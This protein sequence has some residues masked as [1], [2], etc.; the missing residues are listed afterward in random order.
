[1]GQ[2]VYQLGED[3]IFKESLPH[4]S[5]VWCREVAAVVLTQ[6]IYLE[7][8]SLA[9]P[10]LFTWMQPSCM[11]ADVD[12]VGQVE[13]PCAWPAG[14]PQSHTC[15]LCYTVPLLTWIF[16]K[17]ILHLFICCRIKLSY[18]CMYPSFSPHLPAEH[19]FKHVNGSRSNPPASCVQC[20]FPLILL[21]PSLLDS[22]YPNF[23]R[24]VYP[25][26]YSAAVHAMSL[27]FF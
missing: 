14:Q 2:H 5:P 20:I 26:I 27:F 7:A 9:Y 21:L 15:L 11:F 4:S 19:H 6:K 24:A 18:M 1:M 25:I 3:T 10:Y 22:T 13:M 23:P 12:A 8:V 17:W 16:R